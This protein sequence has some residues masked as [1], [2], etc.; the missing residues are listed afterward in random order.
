MKDN[1]SSDINIQ[2]F[3]QIYPPL[4]NKN[5]ISLS[6]AK[7]SNFFSFDKA[8]R[9]NSILNEKKSSKYTN[10]FSIDDF[11]SNI[12]NELKDFTTKSKKTNLD[13]IRNS[14][15]FNDKL[16]LDNEKGEYYLL[17]KGIEFQNMNRKKTNDIRKG[18]TLFYRQSNLILK[19]YDFFNKY[20]PNKENRP[21][22]KNTRKKESC[23]T[24][25][26]KGTL[27]ENKIKM[28]I[29]KL[30]NMKKMN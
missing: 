1:N 14:S 19:I 7:F 6:S 20:G 26:V 23:I 10:T 27:I 11:N 13:V 29:Q 4:P 3:L 28:I 21:M 30:K 5:A 18:L 12:I 17:Y 2:D 22:N 15:F 24:E 25:D 9:R 16:F 8:Y